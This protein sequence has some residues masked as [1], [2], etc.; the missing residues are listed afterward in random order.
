MTTED[1]LLLLN[2]KLLESID[3]ND[4]ETYTEL[5]DVNL[6]AYEPEA[7]GQLV[8]GLAFHA[9]YL[10]RQPGG[11]MKQSTIC[12]PR[13][14]MLGEDAAVVTFVRLSQKSA[15]DTGDS[16]ASCEETRVWQKI[17]GQWKHVHFHRSF[18]GSVELG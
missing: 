7:M 1:E 11:A 8:E 17:N 13:V 5:C 10:T 14:R 3:S 16:V 12:S 2:E 9:F 15:S 4:Y 18:A 6:S